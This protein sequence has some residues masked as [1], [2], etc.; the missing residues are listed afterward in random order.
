MII[1]LKVFALVFSSQTGVDMVR[2]GPLT[3]TALLKLV[4]MQIWDLVPL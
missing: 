1:F 2:N 3:S 4:L